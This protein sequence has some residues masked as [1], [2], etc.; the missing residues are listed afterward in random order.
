MFI[1]DPGYGFF[2]S[3]NR[4]PVQGSKRHRILDPH[5]SEK[6]DPDP[7]QS[8]KQ[9]PDPHQGDKLDPV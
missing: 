3:R 7:H 1:P 5:E 6:Q 8:D 9:D 2:P 4:I